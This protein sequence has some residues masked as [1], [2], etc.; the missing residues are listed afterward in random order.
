MI[1]ENNHKSLENKNAFSKDYEILLDEYNTLKAKYEKLKD[2][3][4]KREVEDKLEIEYKLA[5]S[6]KAESNNECIKSGKIYHFLSN[7]CC[8]DETAEL[9]KK[10]G[11]EAVYKA[12]KTIY[13]EVKEQKEVKERSVENE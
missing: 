8:D 6:Y 5:K 1:P 7:E 10:Y 11:F 4:I 3:T 12:I 9:I 2:E 13:E